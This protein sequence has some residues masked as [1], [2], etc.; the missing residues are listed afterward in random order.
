MLLISIWTDRRMQNSRGRVVHSISWVLEYVKRLRPS[1][2]VGVVKPVQ[3][4]GEIVVYTAAYKGGSNLPFEEGQYTNRFAKRKIQPSPMSRLPFRQVCSW[5]RYG[6]GV[7]VW[8]FLRSACAND[9]VVL[10]CLLLPY[11]LFPGKFFQG[12]NTWVWNSLEWGLRSHR[13]SVFFN[14]TEW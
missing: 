6:I 4:D 9:R 2:C 3:S 12:T 1:L 14:V 8:T 13:P 11:I 7:L 10:L 5:V